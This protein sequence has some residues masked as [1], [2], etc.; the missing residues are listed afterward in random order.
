M[1]I[2]LHL[3]YTLFFFIFERNLNFRDRFSKN[4]RKS[5][6]KKNPSG[7]RGVVPFGAADRRD[8]ASSRFSQILKGAYDGGNNFLQ[9]LGTCVPKHTT[10]HLTWTKSSQRW[11]SEMLK[12]S[13]C[14]KTH[15]MLS[16]T[17]LGNYLSLTYQP[18]HA[19]EEL[20]KCANDIDKQR[21]M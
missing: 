11:H 14:K 13:Y 1:S 19:A 16:A 21:I 10:P 20:I 12:H 17:K 4:N 6:F 8:E 7:G 9:N 2:C 15:I 18:N 3:K 5:N